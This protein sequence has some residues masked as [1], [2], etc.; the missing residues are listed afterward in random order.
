MVKHRKSN[1]SNKHGNNNETSGSSSSEN[2]A[3][4]QSYQFQTVWKTVVGVTCLIVAVY[5]G[6]LGYLETRV[7][8]PFDGE[9]AVQ[10]TGLDVPE[11][12]WGSYRPGVY[13]GL[14]SREPRSP[15][16]GMMWY[17]LAAAAH[18]AG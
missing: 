2:S 10:D 16:F 8:T 15:V 12:Y 6:T 4:I 11:R 1:L 13:F 5:I 14:K 17:E 7:N 3:P 18:K 9:K